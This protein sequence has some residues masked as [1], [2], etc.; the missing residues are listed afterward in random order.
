MYY[1]RLVPDGTRIQ[2]MRGRI[3][4]LVVSA[5]LSVLSVIL[6]F[7][8]GVNLGVD[9]RGGIVVEAKF[10]Q[11]ADFGAIRGVLDPLNLGHVGLQE[12]GSPVDVSLAIERQPGDETHG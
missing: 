8:P 1:V 4:G 11:P 7:T 12:I 9:F 3:A 2:F 6:Y 5:I 10:T